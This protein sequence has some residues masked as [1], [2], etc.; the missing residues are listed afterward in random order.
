M[1]RGAWWAIVPE[2]EK[3]QTKL[4][5]LSTIYIYVYIIYTCPCVRVQLL[6]HVQL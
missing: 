6:S 5:G 1:D 2:I 3:T 4:K